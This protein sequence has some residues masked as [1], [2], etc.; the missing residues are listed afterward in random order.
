M[1][2]RAGRLKVGAND[3]VSKER[4]SEY[5]SKLSVKDGK[6]REARY[7]CAIRRDTQ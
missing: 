3:D 5:I 7:T 1:P 6:Q 4:E 2:I